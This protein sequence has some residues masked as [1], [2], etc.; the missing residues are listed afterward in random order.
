MYVVDE[1]GWFGLPSC[2]RSLAVVVG[3]WVGVG[4]CLI[5]PTSG[6][7]EELKLVAHASL[8]TVKMESRLQA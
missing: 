6:P 4:Q 5:T 8:I 3:V 2:E 7:Q 1:E